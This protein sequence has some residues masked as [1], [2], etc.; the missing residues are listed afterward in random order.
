MDEVDKIAF[1]ETKNGQILSTKS[2]GKTKYYIPGGKRELGE[3]D[4]ETLVREIAEE[5]DVRI[6]K[7]TI[8]YVGTFKAQSDGAKE[9]VLVKM[10]CY[11]AKYEGILKPSSEI[12]EIRWLNYEDLGMISE[13]DKKI[14]RFL[15]EK[16]EL[17]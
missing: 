4:A 12:E 9:G 8:E 3:T 11:K 16:G 17:E 2:K 14:F 15:K 5:L 6:D 10:T 7:T 13:V 1:I